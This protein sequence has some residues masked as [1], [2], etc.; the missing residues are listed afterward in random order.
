MCH[1]PTKSMEKCQLTPEMGKELDALYLCMCPNCATKYRLYRNTDQMEDFL[2]AIESLSDQQISSKDPVEI[3]LGEESVWFT[4]THIA[5]IRELLAYEDA[6]N[7]FSEPKKGR[8]AKQEGD[9]LEEDT[10]RLNTFDLG[11]GNLAMAF[12]EYEFDE[13]DD[14]EPEPEEEVNAGLDVYREYIGKTICHKTLGEGVVA[15]CDGKYITLIF[16]SGPKAGKPV[17]Y[18]LEACLNNGLIKIL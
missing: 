9:D 7:N 11:S 4:Q 12:D 15:D 6:V 18:S 3:E 2:E 13:E 5:E 10:E 17:K 14:H 8:K 16:D 1:K